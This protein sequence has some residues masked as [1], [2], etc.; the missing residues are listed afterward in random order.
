MDDFDATWLTDPEIAENEQLVEYLRRDL[1]IAKRAL[2]LIL[3]PDCWRDLEACREL[4]IA[5]ASAGLSGSDAAL[6]RLEERFKKKIQRPVFET[7][8]KE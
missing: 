2:Q 6:E 4:S 3:N 7:A 5:A 1:D 8:E